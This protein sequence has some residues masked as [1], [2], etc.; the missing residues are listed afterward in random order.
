MWEIFLSIAKSNAELVEKMVNIARSLDFEIASP[1]DA[2]RILQL[3][4]KDSV[5][6]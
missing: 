5:G 4:G 1:S 2:R 6:F 3:R